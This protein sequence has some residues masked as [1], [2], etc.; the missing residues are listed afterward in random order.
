MLVDRNAAGDAGRN[1]S[2]DA[3]QVHRTELLPGLEVSV[4]AILGPRATK[5]RRRGWRG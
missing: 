3:D 5:M 2:L 4:A 1:V